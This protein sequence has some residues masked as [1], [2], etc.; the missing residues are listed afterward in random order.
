[1]SFE[2]ELLWDSPEELFENAPCGYLSTALDGTILRVNRAFT[3][4]TGIAREQLLSGRRFQDLLAPGGRIHYE[5]HFAPLLQMQGSVREIAVELLRAD[6]SRLPALLTSVVRRDEQGTPRLIRT[7]VFDATDRRR[8]EQELLRARR[9]QREIAQ[10]L[11][12]G[13]LSGVLPSTPELTVEVAYDPGARGLEVGGDWY[14]AFW[15]EQDHT[16]GLVVGD[17]VGHGLQSA[18]EMGQL[19]SAV[20]AFA[21]TGLGPESVLEALDRYSARHQV[22]RMATLVYAHLSLTTGW[23][24][25]ACAGQLPPLLLTPGEEPRYL[26]DGRSLPLDSRLA[27]GAPRATSGVQ[28]KAGST[29]LLYSDGLI[30][31]RSESLEQTMERLRAEVSSHRMELPRG[32]ARAIVR[33][34]RHTD[35]HPDDICLLVARLADT[36]LE[37]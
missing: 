26:W 16:V 28:L 6:G 4:W 9:Q 8:Y 11:Q 29:L 31:R 21:S 2:Q 20:R 17:V 13:L 30:E 37:V 3:L 34:L 25:F 32:S 5:T 18:A 14:D 22:G 33:A 7:T 12:H 24:Q 15:L 1:M 10:E 23:L 36:R 19:R 27:G 35:Q